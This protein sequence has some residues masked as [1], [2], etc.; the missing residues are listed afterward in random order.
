MRDLREGEINHALLVL[1]DALK[2]D[3]HAPGW[4]D[5]VEWNA[6]EQVGI[7]LYF[8]RRRFIDG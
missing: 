3:P 6:E 8:H 5:M 2:R 1:A 7:R 4:P